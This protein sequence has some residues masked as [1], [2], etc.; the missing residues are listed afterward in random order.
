MQ[1]LFLFIVLLFSICCTA[2]LG[3]RAT[4]QFLN[5]MTSPRQAAMGGRVITNY[6]YDPDSAL[7]NPAT[8]NHR[9]DNQLSVN[10]VDYLAD[11]SYGTAS[12]AY[13]WDRRT[14][15][16]HAGITYINYGSFDGRDEQGN[17]TGDFSG[18]EAALSIGYAYNIPY[19]DFHVGANV[20]LITSKLDQFTSIGGAVDLGMV[21]NYEK[22]DLNIAAVVRNIGTQ[23]TTYAGINEPLPLEVDVGM[24]QIVPNVPVRW[25]VTLEN[26]QLW[27]VAF[28]NPALS[29]V[30]LNGN[31][32]PDEVGFFD[33]VIRHAIVGV[34]LFPNSGFNIRLGYNFR[35]NA[36]LRVFN[37]R[38]FAGISAGFGVKIGSIR[39]NY[40]YARFNSAATSNLIGLN[41]DLT[42]KK[43]F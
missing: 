32:T 5:L 11:I 42:R 29:Q 43:Y 41:I 1:K 34:E 33:N 25:H 6:D 22:W 15:V 38:S 28:E 13:L 19:T 9:M 8:I 27:N 17:P 26:L 16:I 21:Y 37:Q 12:Y 30:D 2:Q 23:F 4:Y 24:S 39:F 20:K 36:E 40:A 31:T 3:G 7:Y 18:Q 35:R 14:Q 10:Y